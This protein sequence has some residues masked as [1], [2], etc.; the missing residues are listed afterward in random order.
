MP[1]IY[2]IEGYWPDGDA[3][4][5]EVLVNSLVRGQME[6]VHEVSGWPY[7][8]RTCATLN[9][10]HFRLN[11]EWEA[12]DYGSILN[13]ATHGDRGL[14]CLSEGHDQEIAALPD[15][16]EDGF[17]ER[18]FVHFG[19]CQTVDGQ[20]AEIRGF[21]ER[22]GA[23]GVSGYTAN[24]IEWLAPHRQ[25]AAFKPGIALESIYFAFARSIDLA[26]TH[27]KGANGQRRRDNLRGI[28]T[29]LQA[30]FPDCGF[31][32]WLRTPEGIE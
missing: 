11:M 20:D 19:G 14:I 2:C 27:K 24:D 22:S 25:D 4:P 26:L 29:T 3:S 28:E 6:A 15:V 17:A 12:C 16:V 31:K 8:H 5:D 1:H 32:L 23:N 18:C 21:M 30:A 7:M 9:E 10:L 13:F